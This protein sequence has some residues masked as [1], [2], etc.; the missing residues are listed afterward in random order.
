MIKTA[1][2][3]PKYKAG[4][5]INQSLPWVI[6]ILGMWLIV[7]QP[8]GP[9]WEQMPGDLV[10]ARF[11]NYI[12]EHFLRWISGLD[13]SYWTAPFFYPYKNIVAFS[14]NLLG[15]SFF[16]AGWRWAGLDREAAFQGWYI[17]SFCFNYFS[18]LF[19]FSRFKFQPLAAS[20]GAFF[21]SFGLP[22][23]AQENHAQLLYRFGIPLA[24]Y[25]LWLLFEE[26]GLKNLSALLFWFVWQVYLSIY[27][28]VFLAL[29][30]AAMAI[31]LPC[32]EENPHVGNYFGQWPRRLKKTWF[33]SGRRE[34]I[35]NALLICAEMAGLLALLWPYYKV[36]VDYGFSRDWMTVSSML[37]Q[38]Q[39]YFLAD[40]SRLWSL[41]SDHLG[42]V[43]MRWE[44][45]L[46]PGIAI[47]VLT[48]TGFVTLKSSNNR[49]IA[50][51]Y[52]GALVLLV[53]FTLQ[54]NGISIYWLIWNIPG[55]N[56]IRAVTRIELVL[57]WPQAFLGAWTLNEM[58]QIR[59][60]GI[61]WQYMAGLLLT[62][63]LISESIIFP[64]MTYSKAGGLA[65]LEQLKQRIPPSLPK[66]PIISV[67]SS[68][69]AASY[70]DE[71]DAMLLA[72]DLGW[73]TLNGYSGNFPQGFELATSCAQIPNQ[74]IKYFKAENMDKEQ[75]FSFYLA[76]MKRIVPIGF[77][78][79][80]PEWWK[81]LP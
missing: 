73:P 24:C 42:D 44:H 29:L 61:N 30:L 63:V 23:L 20:A 56:S 11:N 27:L 78:D 37:P 48:V 28:G 81:R 67:A 15:S 47:F 80:N 17:L 22:L 31:I 65:R 12:L 35:V 79:C 25:F 53:I 6:F 18:S 75:R 40:N 55:F 5:I 8:L 10:D 19:V 32:L 14:D 57:M 64:T 46:F 70:Q 43:P 72:Q 71:L 13:P 38:L 52:F 41:V 62:I 3:S 45:Q 21:F 34:R 77:S 7:I 76:T 68:G 51:I 1:Q 59:S 4:L 36:T 16:Y 50:M 26:P 9:H 60:Q 74:I 54:F 33:Q 39:S 49:R 66:N 2:G 58:F 69:G